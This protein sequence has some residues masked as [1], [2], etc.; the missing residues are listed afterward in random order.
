MVEID[1]RVVVERV[2]HWCPCCRSEQAASDQR[3]RLPSGSPLKKH[4]PTPAP[5]TPT[6]NE[7]EE[8]ALG[9]FRTTLRKF[10]SE[11]VG[12]YGMG[13]TLRDEAGAILVKD[14]IG[15]YDRL[16]K[17]NHEI[18]QINGERPE[19][20]AAA[21]QLLTASLAPI[22]LLVGLSAEML[23]ANVERA[24]QRCEP[25]TTVLLKRVA[26]ENGGELVGLEH[27][28]KGHESLMRKLLSDLE[29]ENRAQLDAAVAGGDGGGCGAE[30]LGRGTAAIAYAI[31]DALRYTLLLPIDRYVWGVRQLNA[32]LEAAGYVTV[33]QKNYWAAGDSYQGL[34]CSIA[35]SEP[36]EGGGSGSGGG[37]GG[38]GGAQ[39]HF[40]VQVHTADS[41]EMKTGLGHRLYE[42]FRTERDPQTKLALWEKATA[43]AASVPVPEGVLEL[44]TLTTYPQPDEIRLHAELRLFAAQKAEPRVSA[45]MRERFERLAGLEHVLKAPAS[46]ARKMQRACDAAERSAEAAWSAVP[47]AHHGATLP[48]AALDAA[49]PSAPEISARLDDALR[50]TV[51]FDEESYAERCGEAL[52]DLGAAFALLG[53]R[54]MWLTTDVLQGLY[55]YFEADD[56][57]DG[58]RAVIF[59]VQF[60]TA[61]SYALKE[62]KVDALVEAMRAQSDPAERAAL[63]QRAVQLWQA[64]PT[65]AGATSL[66]EQPPQLSASRSESAPGRRAS[67]SR[68]LLNG[69]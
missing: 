68:A 51:L 21:Q 7:L 38:F 23:A 10:G 22:S 43:A 57:G 6:L 36:I 32:E 16:L 64:V 37:S 42:Q 53:T 54:N 15:R 13:L 46:S 47:L 5:S 11:L 26:S 4:A 34:N 66:L 12:R 35:S 33:K 25:T 49:P 67:Q 63:A 1:L 45:A 30:H 3:P 19:S 17:P 50:Y 58:G 27:R 44:P 14:V 28:F 40:E 18:L 69:Y 9:T 48:A 8:V 31:P 60:H 55:A 52:A 39:L 2:S 62:Q 24:A 65:P 59:E 41:F 56:D 29:A 20:A 61:A